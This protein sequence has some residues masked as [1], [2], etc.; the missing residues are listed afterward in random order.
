MDVSGHI[1]RRG[2]SAY[3]SQPRDDDNAPEKI[4]QKLPTWV[5]VMIT[6]TVIG[7]LF[8]MLMVG[9]VFL[10]AASPTH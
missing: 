3:L 5:L 2:V 8:I 1:L 10:S 6:T 7:F 9:G 4:V